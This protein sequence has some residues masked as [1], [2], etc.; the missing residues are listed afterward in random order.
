MLLVPVNILIPVEG[1]DSFQEVFKYDDSGSK[2]LECATLCN[3]T[4]V[5]IRSAP[6]VTRPLLSV[7]VEKC[8]P[9]YALLNGVTD[10]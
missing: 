9:G 10:I 6:L 8:R 1:A 2:D 4:I 3:D 7:S 5:P